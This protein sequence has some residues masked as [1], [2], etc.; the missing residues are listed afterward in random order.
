MKINKALVVGTLAVASLAFV[1]CG[2][3]VEK[4][5]KTDFSDITFDGY[6]TTDGQVY[7]AQ[8]G[9]KVSD[10]TGNTSNSNTLG[11]DYGTTSGNNNSGSISSGSTSGNNNSGSIS[12]GSNSSNSG[13][14]STS[15]SHANLA[16]ASAPNL[17][18]GV[19]D[20]KLTDVS[21]G[22]QDTVKGFRKLHMGNLQLLYDNGEDS[23]KGSESVVLSWYAPSDE[24]I[25]I[26]TLAENT[27]QSTIAL[28]DAKITGYMIT[29]QGTS[30][31]GAF[32]LKNSRLGA[33]IDDVIKDLGYRFTSDTSASTLNA[34]AELTGLYVDEVLNY[35]SVVD[36]WDY[37]ILVD[38]NKF[39]GI[40]A[41]AN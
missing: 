22:A 15:G 10:L 11:S 21:L 26:E 38:N 23:L 3:T 41:S 1:G 9:I 19:T 14:T 7:R 18:A 25:D 34:V 27:T 40:L 30:S 28:D 12:S 35:T 16:D 32:K 37:S 36:S 6:Y 33:D 20:L 24:N 29:L 2:S 13:S 5:A 31:K 39:V 4:A 8:G 17:F